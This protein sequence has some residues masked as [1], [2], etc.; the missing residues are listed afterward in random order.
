MR[1]TILLLLLTGYLVLNQGFM[2]IR[3]PPSDGVPIGELTLIC[4]LAIT[5]IWVVL[6]RMNAVVHLVPFLIWWGCGVGRAV[7]DTG[8]YGMWALRDASHVIDSLFVIV[9]FSFV[10]RPD[11]LDRL[12]RWLA[13]LLPVLS[14]YIMVGYPL[15]LRQ[16][17]LADRANQCRCSAS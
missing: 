14:I 8:E 9:G 3:V 15:K 1:T 16:H 12:F 4:Y 7:F 13:W 10:R 11:D 6:A 2:Q 17:C 5:N